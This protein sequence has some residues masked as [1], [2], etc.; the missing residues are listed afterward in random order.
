MRC[1]GWGWLLE[2]WFYQFLQE[3]N[4]TEESIPLLRH[5]DLVG[6]EWACKSVFL[7]FFLGGSESAILLAFPE[8]PTSVLGLMLK[9]PSSNV[10]SGSYACWG[11]S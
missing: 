2:P 1:H 9:N 11:D 6:L 7:M 8:L 4:K 3:S 10:N 5:S